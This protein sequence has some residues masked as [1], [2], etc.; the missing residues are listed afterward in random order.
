MQS[1]LISMQHMVVFS[2]YVY[3]FDNLTPSLYILFTASQHRYYSLLCTDKQQGTPELQADVVARCKA[4]APAHGE[5]W[6]SESK[7]T[8]NRRLDKEAILRKVVAQNFA[9]TATTPGI[10]AL[11]AAAAAAAAAAS[12]SS[13]AQS[14]SS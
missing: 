9:S 6:C 1:S 7:K 8:E 11:A 3:M 2:I 14:S 4:A 13:A 5:M 12:S 10:T